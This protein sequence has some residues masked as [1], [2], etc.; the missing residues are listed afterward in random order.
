M[1]DYYGFWQG[2]VVLFAILPA[3]AGAVGGAF[4]AR[5]KGRRGAG[6]IAAL[7]GGAALGLG[8]FLIAVLVFRA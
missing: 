8:V 3:M 6:L 1:M 5:R 2:F 7:L 4:W